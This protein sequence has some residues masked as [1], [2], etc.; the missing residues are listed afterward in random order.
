MNN[1][2]WKYTV[3]DHQKYKSELLYIIDN[4]PSDKQTNYSDHSVITDFE[5]H[6][7]TKDY[8]SFIFREEY[9]GGFIER[10]MEEY[11]ASEIRIR[12]LW[13]QKYSKGGGHRWHPHPS[14]NISCVYFIHLE[15]PRDGTEFFDGENIIRPEVSEGDIICF[16]SFLPHRSPVIKGDRKKVIISINMDIRGVDIDR[17]PC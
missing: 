9:I 4:S 15:D 12:H 16:P 17:I 6:A 3:P 5:Y 1:L 11:C 7:E 8:A 10:V 2:P 14:S 13:F